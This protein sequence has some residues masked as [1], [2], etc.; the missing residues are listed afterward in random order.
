MM[1]CAE[2]RVDGLGLAGTRWRFGSGSGSGISCS[3]S[4]ASSGSGSGSGC[5]RGSVLWTAAGSGSGSGWGWRKRGDCVTASTAA[6]VSSR[7]RRIE[8]PTPRASG[9]CDPPPRPPR[10]RVRIASYPSRVIEPPAER[11]RL[12]VGARVGPVLSAR[13]A[14][15]VG[16]GACG[17]SAGSKGKQPRCSSRSRCATKHAP[18]VR[19]NPPPTDQKSGRNIVPGGLP[20]RLGVGWRAAPSTHPPAVP[21]TATG[22]H[23]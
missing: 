7:S 10:E 11:S 4:S 3:T 21:A 23:G 18:L 14:E 9:D 19:G 13:G 15:M 22:S 2:S 1:C 17:H 5:G 12:R 20:R 8:S 6:L 16:A